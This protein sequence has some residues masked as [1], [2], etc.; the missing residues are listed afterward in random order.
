MIQLFHSTS[1]IIFWFIII[2]LKREALI[3]G[4]YFWSFCFVCFG[5]I[6]SFNFRF[7]IRSTSYFCL[8]CF[9]EL[10]L[11]WMILWLWSFSFEIWF[12]FGWLFCLILMVEPRSFFVLL[13]QIY[14]L[15]W[16]I[17]LKPFKSLPVHWYHLFVSIRYHK[18]MAFSRRNIIQSNG[19][20]FV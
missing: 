3:C 10:F 11:L 5:F 1:Q 7:L 6:F 18:K 16:R 15:F 13:Y 17:M 20:V 8:F 12:S 4:N 9:S 19:N 14:F 2:S